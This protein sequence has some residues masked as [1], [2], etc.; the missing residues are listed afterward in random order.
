[1]WA[2]HACEV[3]CKGQAQMSF[4]R[5]RWCETYKKCFGPVVTA[6]TGSERELV[7]FS[8][9]WCSLFRYNLRSLC[10]GDA[11]VWQQQVSRRK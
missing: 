5:N 4:K 10:E 2:R 1:M 7:F 6:E 3:A 8:V 11:T 9:V